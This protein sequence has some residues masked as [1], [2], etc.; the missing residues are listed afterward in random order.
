VLFVLSSARK[1]VWALPLLAALAACDAILGLG[2]PID[3]GSTV[4]GAPDATVEGGGQADGSP[5]Y[6]GSLADTATAAPDSTA[7]ADSADAA[8]NPPDSQPA[9]DSAAPP[10]TGMPL[11][12]PASPDSDP[13]TNQPPGFGCQCRS[14]ADCADSGSCCCFAPGVYTICDSRHNCP[15]YDNGT[16][17]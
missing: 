5:G 1:P 13:C 9:P 2:D 4:Q 17:L 8:S 6:D 11:D 16:C 14:N 7:A 12:A 15:I 3:G 10:D